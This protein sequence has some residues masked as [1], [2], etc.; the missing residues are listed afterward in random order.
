M[1]ELGRAG[2]PGATQGRHLPAAWVARTRRLHRDDRQSI[3]RREGD[4]LGKELSQG[5]A[6]PGH[7]RPPARVGVQA[8]R[9]RRGVPAGHPADADLLERVTVVLPALGRRGPLRVERRG[10]GSRHRRPVDRHRGLDQRR[11][12]AAHLRC[13][14][15]R[16]RRDRRADDRDGP[17]NGGVPAGGGA[18]DGLR[19]HLS[20]RHGHRLSDDRERREALRPLHGPVDRAGRQGAP[21]TRA[22]VRPR[23]QSG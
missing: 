19:G 1:A 11:I 13:R 6:R 9:A 23:P 8:V 16:G 5:G 14:A 3:G 7:H 20:D 21:A 2:C 22:D 15:E 12:R 18:R 10:R 4:P 17:P